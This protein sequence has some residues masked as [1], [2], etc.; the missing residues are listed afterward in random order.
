MTTRYA[1]VPAPLRRLALAVRNGSRQRRQVS[2][3]HALAWRPLKRVVVGAGPTHYDGWV[4][5]D[6]QAL[7]L[8]EP[9]TWRRFVAPGTLDAI[10]AEHVW[11]HLTPEQAVV[12]AGTCFQFL[13]PG[14]YL[15]VAVPDGHHPDPAYINDVRPGGTGDGAD[16]HKVL[17]THDTFAQVFATAG[18]EVRKYE[19]F[20]A[21]GVFHAEPWDEKQGLIR[22]S[23]RFDARNAQ[24]LVYTSIVLDAVRKTGAA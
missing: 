6:M 5:T 12:A 18:F 13:K 21:D 7:N 22:R 24:S 11:E 23:Q 15:R 8:L 4:S 20:D 16:D 9:A 14:G 2:E 19:Y 10:L 1:W 17:Y 3:L